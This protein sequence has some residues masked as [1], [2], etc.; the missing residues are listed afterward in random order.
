MSP[1]LPRYL[2]DWTAT[3]ERHY[4]KLENFDDATTVRNILRMVQSEVT[5]ELVLQ[6]ALNECGSPE[7]F[8]PTW[9]DGLRELETSLTTWLSNRSLTL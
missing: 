7:D 9:L 6:S 3:I 4:E 1:R 2:L 5:E 8:D